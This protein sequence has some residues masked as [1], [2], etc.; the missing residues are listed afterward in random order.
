MLARLCRS[1]QC[2]EGLRYAA[3][4][5]LRKWGRPHIWQVAGS[6]CTCG[7]PQPGLY[8]PGAS[9]SLRHTSTFCR[10]HPRDTSRRG[11]WGSRYHLLASRGRTVPTP[12]PGAQPAVGSVKSALCK[13]QWSAR[14]SGACGGVAPMFLTCFRKRGFSHL[15]YLR[16]LSQ[17]EPVMGVVGLSEDRPFPCTCVL[18]ACQ[19][20]LLAC[21]LPP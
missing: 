9:S 10:C 6:G 20:R 8:V 14:P 19:K 15:L 21:A 17:K 12:P 16:A 3:F 7:A 2:H 4:L 1:E 11:D 5:W 13:Q 18:T